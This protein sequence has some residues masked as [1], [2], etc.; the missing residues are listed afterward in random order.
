MTNYVHQ[1]AFQRWKIYDSIAYQYRQNGKNTKIWHGHNDFLLLVKDKDDKSK[2]S[3]QAPK[4]IPEN[5]LIDFDIGVLN[6]EENTYYQQWSIDKFNENVARSNKMKEQ[7]Q[8]EHM[9][10]DN[11]YSE[12]ENRYYPCFDHQ[13]PDCQ[14][15]NYDDE[16]LHPN[17][18]KSQ[19]NQSIPDDNISDI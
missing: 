14:L 1:A 19:H 12:L 4:L 3:E 6:E 7:I 8:T 18:Q 9:R 15:C 17:A 10:I 2:W 13:E 16:Q 5:L 11:E